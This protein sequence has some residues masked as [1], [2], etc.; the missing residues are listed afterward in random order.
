MAVV[1]IR[2][3]A[4]NHHLWVVRN[5]LCVRRSFWLNVGNQKR[6]QR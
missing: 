5:N 6:E 4:S 1:P 2:R 3:E